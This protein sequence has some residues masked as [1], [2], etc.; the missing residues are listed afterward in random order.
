MSIDFG[1]VAKAI[2]LLYTMRQETD[3]SLSRMTSR[4]D[5]QLGSAFAADPAPPPSKSSRLSRSRQFLVDLWQNARLAA[6]L[7]A[8][9]RRSSTLQIAGVSLRRLPLPLNGALLTS[10]EALTMASNGSPVILGDAA[11]L[12]IVL[13]PAQSIAGATQA[14]DL[15]EHVALATPVSLILAAV[16]ELAWSLGGPAWALFRSI[17]AGS[18]HPSPAATASIC[19]VV[20]ATEVLFG[21][22]ERVQFKTT[23]SNS[24]LLEAVRIWALQAKNTGTVLEVMHGVPVPVMNRYFVGLVDA[25]RT[26]RTPLQLVPQIPLRGWALQAPLSD[27]GY[28]CNLAINRIFVDA[29]GM[30]PF[31]SYQELSAVIETALAGEA[32]SARHFVFFGGTHSSEPFFQSSAYRLELLMLGWIRESIDHA[33]DQIRLHYLPH[34]AHGQLQPDVVSVLE[35]LVDDISYR[36]QHWYFLADYAAGL[37]SSSVFEAASLG[38]D[39]FCPVIPTDGIFV[40][41]MS[42]AMLQTPSGPDLADIHAGIRKMLPG[43]SR[44]HLTTRERLALVYPQLT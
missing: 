27:P 24:V 15:P 16:P 43:T 13:D 41:E 29:L 2:D 33:P 38:A 22:K 35:A 17:R 34:P 40:E 36:S 12:T 39:V 25:P 21:R 28:F 18:A 9:L 42:R 23:T 5:A 26:H 20:L 4:L 19:A 6:G 3:A 10:L 1:Y 11:D 44:D 37:F 32:T 31:S 14:K 7:R 8:K 30:R